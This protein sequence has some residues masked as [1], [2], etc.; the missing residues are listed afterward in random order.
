MD[1]PARLILARV[2][3]VVGALTAKRLPATMR[4]HTPVWRNWQ[5]RRIQ[6]PLRLKTSC[7]FDSLHRHSNRPLN[8]GLFLPRQARFGPVICPATP[9]LRALLLPRQVAIYGYA[10]Q[11]QA[12]HQVF[13]LLR[14]LEASP[15][16][17]MLPEN[18]YEQAIGASP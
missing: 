12:A 8:G 13:V 6:N 10:L 11:R 15:G 4:Q 1:G 16:K 7:G 3:A 14:L 5:T 9:V 2:G 17:E 18:R